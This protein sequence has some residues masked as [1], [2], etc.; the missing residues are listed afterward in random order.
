MQNPTNTAEADMVWRCYETTQDDFYSQ[1]IF[2]K[3]QL[4]FFFQSSS[5][6]W[7]QHVSNSIFFLE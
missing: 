7:V 6:Q 5:Q 3:P 4:K 1:I 2:F